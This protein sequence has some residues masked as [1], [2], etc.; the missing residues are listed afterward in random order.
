MKSRC[1][2]AFLHFRDLLIGSDNVSRLEAWPLQK[3]SAKWITETLSFQR[4]FAMNSRGDGAK[5]DQ[6][7]LAQPSS[8]NL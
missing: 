1:I 3:N 8:F 5:V 7:T 4:Q 2:K 6:P